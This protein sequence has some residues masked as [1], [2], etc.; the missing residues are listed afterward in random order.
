MRVVEIVIKAID[1]TRE[2]I[3]NIRAGMT[4][5]AEDA[6]SGTAPAGGA[7]V[8]LASKA[9]LV[10]AA[11]KAG[12]EI[13]K[14]LWTWVIPIE[15][16]ARAAEKF[17][18]A[19][20]K[21]KKWVKEKL[22]EEKEAVE[23]VTDAYERKDKAASKV[24][25]RSIEAVNSRFAPTESLEA[26]KQ[27]EIAEI[28]RDAADA[29]RISK[30]QKYAD[31]TAR[32]NQNDIDASN[33]LRKMASLEDDIRV[34]PSKKN[35]EALRETKVLIDAIYQKNIL[36]TREVED[37]TN[38]MADAES[39]FQNSLTAYDTSR[40]EEAKVFADMEKEVKDKNDL[41]AHEKRLFYLRDE[42]AYS[43][44]ISARIV[45]KIA[46][47]NDVAARAWDEYKDPAKRDE[48]LTAEATEAGFAQTYARDS[49]G[50]AKKIE[51]L[52]A[53]NQNVE[54]NL[55][56]YEKRVY[57]VMKARDQVKADEKSLRM[58]EN[59]TADIARTID[60]T[61]RMKG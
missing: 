45:D 14:I 2:A 55:N 50:L 22:T 42:L 26:K 59:H 53:W 6:R 57:E 41:K 49:A 8:D 17:N 23:D 9:A 40:L 33:A 54:D 35:L 51:G 18:S 32:K 10:V 15:R 7:L 60:Q 31:I 25:A 48:R 52:Q 5:M 47:A 19:M 21:S 3:A 34:D 11:F 16:A 46:R 39:A 43:E 24:T 29:E 44:K 36:L 61:L 27:T 28:K 1:Q 37:A 20:E 58:I 30:A 13:G 4:K 38:D 56:Q 12:Y